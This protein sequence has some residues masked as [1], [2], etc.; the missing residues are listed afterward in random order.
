MVT[1]DGV[2]LLDSAGCGRHA[3]SIKKSNMPITN[4]HVR[5][6]DV[7]AVSLRWKMAKVNEYSGGKPGVESVM[8]G[9]DWRL[10]SMSRMR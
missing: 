10:S 5:N 4:L 8:I 6:G 7:M 1:L 2:G 3:L 9:G